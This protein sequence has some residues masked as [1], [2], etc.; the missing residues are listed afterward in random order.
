MKLLKILKAI[1]DENRLRIFNLIYQRELCV[2]E[3]ESLSEMNQSNVSRHLIKLKDAEL[4]ASEKNGQFVYY[5]IN[6]ATI[7][8]FPFL[9]NVLEQELVKV[10]AFQA[11]VQKL[12]AL[13]D[14]S[15]ECIREQCPKKE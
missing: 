3:I 14:S 6:Q 11:D 1:A 13:S 15:L 8:S 5:R 7:A 10:K 4:I 9:Q 2:C 12:Q